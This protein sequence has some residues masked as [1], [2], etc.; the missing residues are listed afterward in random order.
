LKPKRCFRGG[1]FFASYPKFF[2]YLS[3]QADKYS[4]FNDCKTGGITING[5]LQ[6]HHP[7]KS[8]DI[9]QANNGSPA[10]TLKDMVGHS[11]I[12]TT[13]SF[14]IKST[15]ANKLKAV[16]ALERMMGA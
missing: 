1:V 10:H 11:D 15:D 12:K 7:R 14:Y 13:M 8:H 2:A 9:S 4:E 5:R 3:A 16:E 6:A